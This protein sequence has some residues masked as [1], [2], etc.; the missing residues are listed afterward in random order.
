MGRVQSKL[1]VRKSANGG[2]STF[3]D[4][5]IGVVTLN[6]SAR[7]KRI[8]IQVRPSGEVRLTVPLAVDLER[9]K[10]FLRSRREW[11]VEAQRRQAARPAAVEYTPAEIAQLRAKAVEYLPKRLVEIAAHCGFKHGKI[12]VRTTRS[13]WGSC[14]SNNDISLS[15][16]LITLPSHLIDFVIL[17]ELSHTIHHNHSP[18]FHA[19]V[20]R[21]TSGHEK[22]LHRELRG[23]RCGVKIDHP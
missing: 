7:A 16:F 15:T 17:H 12:S 20:D 19:L 21:L 13:K 2:V 8:S 9:A 18:Q 10:E 6:Q 1:F 11:I 4:S 3:S 23:Y 5:A 22:E 14:S